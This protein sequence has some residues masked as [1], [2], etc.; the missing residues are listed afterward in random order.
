M[1]CECSVLGHILRA[2]PCPQGN[3]QFT[4]ARGDVAEGIFFVCF[5]FDSSVLNVVERD[6][7][8][9]LGLL[10]LLSAL[11]GKGESDSYTGNG[12]A[13]ATHALSV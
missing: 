10:L 7:M 3:Q 2:A 5:I 4:C 11:M 6:T 13:F 9:H 1:T 8:R 12:I